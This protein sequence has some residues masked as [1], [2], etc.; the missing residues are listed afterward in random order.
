MTDTVAGVFKVFL[1]WG[2]GLSV[3]CTGPPP[4]LQKPDQRSLSQLAVC[5]A[6]LDTGVA[7]NLEAAFVNMGGRV[8][9]EYQSYVRSIIFSQA[10]ITSED[11]RLIYT[12]YVKCVLE[13]DRAQRRQESIQTSLLQCQSACSIE[14]A[15]CNSGADAPFQACLTKSQSR[16]LRECRYEFGHS[17]DQCSNRLCAM[18]KQNSSYWGGRYCPSEKAL[19]IQ[20]SGQCESRYARCLTSCAPN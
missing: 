18:N 5:G 3:S 20:S 16:C 19:S 8:S 6:G 9:A 13:I 12:E 2:I 7:A 14:R 17:A 10:D 4:T 11:K 15:S 1:G